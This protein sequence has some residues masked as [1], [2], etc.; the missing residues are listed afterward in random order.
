[1]DLQEEAVLRLKILMDA[2]K[3]VRQQMDILNEIWDEYVV[4]MNE[5]DLEGTDLL[6]TRQ[7]LM[8]ARR[9]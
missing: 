3:L 9:F 1:M 8:D 4:D 2:Y 6:D 5:L 7:G